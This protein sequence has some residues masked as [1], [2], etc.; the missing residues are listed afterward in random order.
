MANG[1]E[2]QVQHAL[3]VLARAQNVFGGDQPPVD[4]P[5]FAACRELEDNVGRGYF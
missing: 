2:A 5:V 1:L 4:P 3:G